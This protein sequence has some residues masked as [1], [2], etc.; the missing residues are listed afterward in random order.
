MRA[1]K[2]HELLACLERNRVRY[3]LIG[4]LGA[5]LHKSKEAAN[6]P[7]DQRALPTLKQLLKEIDSR[8]RQS[9]GG[10]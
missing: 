9:G 3:V 8:R 4:G 10:D 6:R 5:V 1:L 2:A 7:K